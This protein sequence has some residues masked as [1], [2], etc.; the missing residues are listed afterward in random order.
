[1]RSAMWADGVCQM[2]DGHSWPWGES[3]DLDDEEFLYL[4]DDESLFQIEED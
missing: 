2:L 4:L 1:V 3:D